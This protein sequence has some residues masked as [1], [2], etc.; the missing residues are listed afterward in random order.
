MSKDDYH[1]LV[2]RILVYLYDRLKKGLNPSQEDLNAI[3]LNAEVNER[4]WHYVLKSLMDY[5][6]IEGAARIDVDNTYERI[7]GMQNAQITPRGIEYLT[8][9]AFMEKAKRFLK[10]AKDII[11]FI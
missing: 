9:N 11:P 10:D 5:G 4:Y 1:V 3:A 2:Y 8:D 6:F 7:V